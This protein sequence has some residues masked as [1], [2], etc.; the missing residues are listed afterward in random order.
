[1][2]LIPQEVGMDTY[3][4]GFDFEVIL[5]LLVYRGENYSYPYPTHN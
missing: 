5:L 2:Y 4:V 3:R 1:M